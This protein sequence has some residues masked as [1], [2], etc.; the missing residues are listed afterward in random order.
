MPALL[1]VQ[2][3]LEDVRACKQLGADGVVVGCLTP[4]GDVDMGAMGPLLDAARAQVRP[5]AAQQQQALLLAAVP[6]VTHTPQARAR[7][8]THVCASRTWMSHS[9]A[10]LTWRD[11]ARLRWSSW[12][13]LACRAC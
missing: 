6:F 9:T 7:A 12:S 13:S 5:A 2:V 3:M 1:P 4:D 11:T 8:R 10:R